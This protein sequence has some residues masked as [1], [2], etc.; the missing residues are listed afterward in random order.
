MSRGIGAKQSA[1]LQYLADHG[2]SSTLETVRWGL[3]DGAHPPPA[4]ILDATGELSASWNTSLSRA[5]KGLTEAEPQ[6]IAVTKRKLLSLEEF[7]EHYP[8]KTLSHRNRY[9]RRQLLPVLLSDNNPQFRSQYTR[10]GNESYNIQQRESAPVVL[11]AGKI[12][13][14]IEPYLFGQLSATDGDARNALFRL[15]AKG[16]EI[17]LSDE[18]SARSGFVDYADA[19]KATGVLSADLIRAIDEICD[20]VLPKERE[21]HL[22]LKSK[23]Y[24]V[25]DFGSRGH[26]SSLKPESIVWLNGECGGLL[27]QLDGYKAPQRR[28]EQDDGWMMLFS[29]ERVEC[30]ELKRLIDATA[31]RPFSFVELAA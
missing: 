30:P 1:I 31:L 22:N 24:S 23:L 13:R 18:L 11:K 28:K 16:K 19:V 12:W 5:A 29:R 2:G 27:S 10:A 6:R 9:L 20:L 14:R 25:V 3:W 17:F 15:L 26:A 21:Y 4:G 8:N 7:L